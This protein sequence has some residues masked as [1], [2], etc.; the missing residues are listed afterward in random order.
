[1]SRAREAE[2]RAA[3]WILA[4]EDE[5]WTES[6]QAGLDSWLAQSDGHKAAYWRLK[7]SWREAD[8]I[9][10][11]GGGRSEPAPRIA[12]MTFVTDQ[13]SYLHLSL[14]NKDRKHSQPR[15]AVVC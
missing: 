3:Q 11:L 12:L 9:A 7:H 4:Q 10:A 14:Q 6:D 8:R 13:R 15:W 2:D 5:G 1:M